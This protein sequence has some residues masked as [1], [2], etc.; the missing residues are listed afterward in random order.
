MIINLNKIKVNKLYV[1]PII[2]I[3]QSHDSFIQLSIREE[4]LKKKPV[5]VIE[6]I[7]KE[8]SNGTECCH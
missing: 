5:N 3:R 2:V 6:R 1:G 4:I 8:L 7:V